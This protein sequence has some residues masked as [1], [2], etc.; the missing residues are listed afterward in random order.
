MDD[1]RKMAA[2]AGGSPMGKRWNELKT[3]AESDA[4][5]LP[6]LGIDDERAGEI[7]AIVNDP[8]CF[9][10]GGIPQAAKQMEAL[11]KEAE[12]A[13]ASLRGA[14]RRKLAEYRSSYEDTYDMTALPQGAADE[15]DAL[16]SEAEG[17][18]EL[19][20]IPYKIKSFSEDFKRRNA[21]RLLALVNPAPEP[22]ETPPDEPPIDVPPVYV[23][24]TVPIARLSAKGYGKPAITSEQDADEY[25][26]A[27]KASIVAVLSDG[28][29]VSI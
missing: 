2:F 20:S 14:E 27:L 4:E 18:L 26:A 23:P 24:K 10:S 12:A 15:F 6:E 17:Q 25:L 22:P 3:F 28:D 5:Y 19:V 9:K 7:R 1:L 16:F 11:K 29:I 8:E 13:R 21:A